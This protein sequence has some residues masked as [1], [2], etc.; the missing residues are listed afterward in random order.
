MATWRSENEQSYW[1]SALT[2]KL[3]VSGV[4]CVE[5]GRQS[6]HILAERLA[7][8]YFHVPEGRLSTSFQPIF[9]P[10]DNSPWPELLGW[11]VTVGTM[12]KVEDDA[13]IDPY[14]ID[15]RP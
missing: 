14:I 1:V 10:Q 9:N 2:N 4:L 8:R 6:M 11:V 5:N 13:A 12:T 3:L 7:K 15:D